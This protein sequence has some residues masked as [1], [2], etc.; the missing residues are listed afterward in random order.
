M[1]NLLLNIW[2]LLN[3][4]MVLAVAIWKGSSSTE[5]DSALGKLCDEVWRKT[6]RSSS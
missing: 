5:L 6:Y 1:K 2:F 4:P 3:V